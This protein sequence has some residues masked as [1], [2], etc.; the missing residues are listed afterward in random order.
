MGSRESPGNSTYVLIPGNIAILGKESTKIRCAFCQTENFTRV[1]K[2]ISK[3]GII[4]GVS[5]LIC[6]SWLL[7]LLVL[8][9]DA[10]RDFSHFCPNCNSN[11]GIYKPVFS[12]GWI[13]LLVLLGI[14][15]ILLNIT[16]IIIFLVLPNIYLDDDVSTK[17][18]FNS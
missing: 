5:C 8:L 6:G 16:F 13:A 9:L 2:K 17:D 3:S 10:F 12:N 15:T 14:G 7:A 4:W 18:L 11:I 1:E